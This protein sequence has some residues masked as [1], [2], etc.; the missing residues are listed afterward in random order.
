LQAVKRQEPRA[1]RRYFC[2]AG[3]AL[4][5]SCG[6]CS[7][8]LPLGDVTGRVTYQGKPVAYAA[9][10]FH[11]VT[12]EKS[13]LGW[14]DE[15]GYYTLQYTLSKPGALIGRH[16]VQVRT[17]PQEGE[18]PVP[19]PAKYGNNSQVEFEVKGGENELNIELSEK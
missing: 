18:Q 3:A 6:G 7:K 16:K 17:Y 1:R 5:A 12:N 11:P 10:E 14:T 15:D 9:V 8:G 2:L 4:L 13:S 19:V